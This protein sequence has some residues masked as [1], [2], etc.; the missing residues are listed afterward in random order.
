MQEQTPPAGPASDAKAEPVRN[1]DKPA[2]KS[3]GAMALYAAVLL[4]GGLIAFFLTPDG[5]RPRP[6][7]TV[8]GSC[9]ITMLLCA[10]MAS[11]IHKS[12]PLGM[13]GIHLGL[14]MPLLLAV[15][16]GWRAVRAGA[17][18]DE[19][20]EQH[21]VFVAQQ[22]ADYPGDASAVSG[23]AY[24]EWALR[25]AFLK[26]TQAGEVGVMEGPGTWAHS[27]AA[28]RVVTYDK[29]VTRIVLWAL[30]AASVGAFFLILST[31]PKPEARV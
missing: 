7:L 26:A 1:P 8:P 27:P 28:R 6:A 11:L 29:S 17:A 19:Y 3:P 5:A 20:R 12:K 14:V 13:I 30:S 31:R 24:R 16:F 4:A 2:L 18:V 22:E 15:G 21:A 25:Q 10:A 23:A 9:A